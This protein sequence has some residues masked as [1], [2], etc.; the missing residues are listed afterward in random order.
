MAI[1]WSLISPRYGPRRPLH[2]F[3]WSGP[4]TLFGHATA[5]SSPND[6]CVTPN[7]YTLTSVAHCDVS[8]EPLVLHV[9]DTDDRYSVMQC[10]D[11]WTNTFAYIGRRATGTKEGAF[12]FAPAAW[13]GL[14]PDGMTRITTPST[15]F[16]IN[17]RYAVSG[18]DDF[19]TV[20]RLQEQ[21]WATPLSRYPEPPPSAWRTLGDR[22]IAPFNEGVAEELR[23][24]E[25]LRAWMA[26]FPPPKDDR[27]LVWSF[28]PLGLLGGPETY[29][30]ADADLVAIFTEAA[31][32]GQAK[33]G[34][35]AMEGM[36][37]PVNG[38]LQA[39]HAFD[40]NTDRLEL[41][42]IDSPEW[43]I[44]NR[45]RAHEARAGMAMVSL[46]GN[47]G[48]EVDCAV[49]FV[50][51]QDALLSGTHRYVIHFDRTPPTDAFWSLTMYDAVNCSL[52][53]NPINR[54]SIGDRTTGVRYNA[55]GSLDLYLHHASPGAEQEVNW[56]PTPAGAFLLILR[57]YQPQAAV[58]DGSYVL[59]P[60]TRL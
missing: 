33:V 59:P 13:N 18:P 4:V 37:A 39:R 29:L 60:I 19:P 26:L 36:P 49:A 14:V 20:T 15:M 32:A 27:P 30:H 35:L 1:R 11:A 58:L 54:Y 31:L 22:N 48:Y 21:T 43:E 51:G 47:H 24:W 45:H 23:F 25:Q 53:E 46:W 56:L 44:P 42:T 28:V 10:I 7:N 50:D 3:R 55:D 9:P 41:G 5:L 52:V 2:S 40:Y 38:W 34:T 17:A 6:H 57:M 16:T 8:N 12:L